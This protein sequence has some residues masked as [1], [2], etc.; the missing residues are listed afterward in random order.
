M[1]K[2]IKFRKGSRIVAAGCT[3][4]SVSA[5]MSPDEAMEDESVT[6]SEKLLASIMAS[7]EDATL[8]AGVATNAEALLA[9]SATEQSR[10]FIL[11]MMVG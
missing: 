4:A 11:V 10:R 7:C 8:A 3:H 9:R 5:M 2:D 6:A 1:A